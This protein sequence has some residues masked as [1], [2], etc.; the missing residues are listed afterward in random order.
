MTKPF[1]LQTNLIPIFVALVLAFA[2]D[3]VAAPGDVDPG[4]NPRLTSTVTL[5]QGSS[6]TA[7]L[8][9]DGKWILL[10]TYYNS[11]L[12]P[13]GR[14]IQRVNPDGTLDPT[15]DC[16]ACL[17]FN[18]TIA[19]V[20]GD[21]KILV[22]G[23][24]K[25]IR[26]H[27]NG[28]LDT[29]FST[30]FDPTANPCGPRFLFSLAGGKTILHCRVGG[31]STAGIDTVRRLNNNGT[32]DPEFSVIDLSAAPRPFIAQMIVQSDGKLFMGGSFGSTSGGWLRRYNSDGTLDNSF[33]ATP[34][35]W[36]A[37]TDQLVD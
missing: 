11:N 33:T 2:I 29:T 8:Q 28:S 20:Q 9:P 24:N 13:G 30:T 25:L 19:E 16:P 5:N 7:T 4:F 1:A 32:P 17:A 34:N 3:I 36:V 22:G 18:P 23:E 10:G 15:F 14:F 37:G 27:P 12:A 26:L 21:G 35:F 31:Q 6:V